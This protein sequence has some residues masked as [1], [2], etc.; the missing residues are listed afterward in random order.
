M[1]CTAASHQG[2]I[3]EPATSLLRTSETHLVCARA[4]V[5][6]NSSNEHSAQMFNLLQVCLYREI[7]LLNYIGV[8]FT[9]EDLIWLLTRQAQMHISDSYL[10]YFPIWMWPE[11]DQ[12]ISES[13]QVFLLLKRSWAI[14]DLCHMGGKKIWIGSLE[15][16][17]AVLQTAWKVIFKIYNRVTLILRMI[18]RTIS[19]SL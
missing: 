19:L 15:P 10:I 13:M 18:V 17:R 16:C 4:V 14:S 9:G 12:R 11:T 5:T 1:T 8:A 7:P 6:D 2:A 3:K